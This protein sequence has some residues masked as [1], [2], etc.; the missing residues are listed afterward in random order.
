[1][2]HFSS[3]STTKLAVICKYIGILLDWEMHT[4]KGF[5][6]HVKSI[7]MMDGALGSCVWRITKEIKA[8]FSTLP[9]RLCGRHAGSCNYNDATEACNYDV[10]KLSEV[11]WKERNTI[12]DRAQAHWRDQQGKHE[13]K[14]ECISA[15]YFIF[16]NQLE[17]NI[18]TVELVVA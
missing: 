7:I 13:E 5:C 2:E 3:E 15:R 6:S 12:G 18:L 10:K 16:A 4:K 17:I 14:P 9:V 1:M 8:S 11:Q